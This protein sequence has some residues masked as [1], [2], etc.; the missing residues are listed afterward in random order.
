[1]QFTRMPSSAS[2]R[3]HA[4]VI[5]CT[6]AF[7]APY[8]LDPAGVS[9]PN[10]DPIV[11]IE[12]CFLGSIARAAPPPLRP[13]TR[14]RPGGFPPPKAAP[15]REDGAVFPGSPPP[16][17]PRG[18]KKPPRGFPR[19]DPAKLLAPHAQQRPPTADPRIRHRNVQ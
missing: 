5:A 15:V 4:W 14:S 3:A 2:S 12:P 7:V 13:P 19:H 16:P 11:M 9:R 6:P 1:M 8:A 18:G 17:P 10:T